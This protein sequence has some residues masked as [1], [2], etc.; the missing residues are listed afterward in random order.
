MA[1]DE[2]QLAW[3]LSISG[4]E[5]VKQKIAELNEQFNRGEIS[6]E[7]YTK[8]LK[9]ANS[10]LNALKNNSALVTRS[11]QAQHPQLNTL[12]RAM[13]GLSR[14]M[15][16]VVLAQTAMNVANLLFN[17]QAGNRQQIVNELAAA[18]RD[19]NNALTDDAKEEASRRVAALKSQL[20]EYDKQ[21][22]QQ[23]I[24]NTITFASSITLIG[25]SVIGALP[26][27]KE[28]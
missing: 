8:G 7:D 4:S 1:T 23:T 14:V 2:V 3:K 18:E 17:Q 27:L 10:D 22:T 6:V 5:E 26:K 13:S 19:Y 25:T 11:W 9:A 15:H 24:S 16:S 20:E 21:M 28:L 12:S